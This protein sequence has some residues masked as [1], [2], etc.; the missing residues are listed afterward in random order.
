LKHKKVRTLAPVRRSSNGQ[1]ISLTENYLL[2]DTVTKEF[3]CGYQS[4]AH[5]T[6]TPKASKAHIFKGGHLISTGTDWTRGL[7]AIPVSVALDRENAET[8]K[9]QNKIVAMLEESAANSP[10]N[11]PEKPKRTRKPA[12]TRDVSRAVEIVANAEMADRSPTATKTPRTRKPKAE[13]AT[14]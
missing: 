5:A 8:A 3:I 12:A 1:P 4:F 7:S 11:A 9:G 6:Y 13:L 14:A 2:F 10:V